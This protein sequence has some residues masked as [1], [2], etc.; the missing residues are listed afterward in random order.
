MDGNTASEARP[1][2]VQMT[3]AAWKHLGGEATL[4]LPPGPPPP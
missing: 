2:V 3:E 4:P 1:I